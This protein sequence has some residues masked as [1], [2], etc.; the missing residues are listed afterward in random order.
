ML[1][2]ALPITSGDIVAGGGSIFII[3]VLNDNGPVL[4]RL[5]SATGARHRA[6]VCPLH[7]SELAYSGLP[8]QDIVVRCVPVWS[9]GTCHFTKL[10]HV[11]N[12]LRDR[13]TMALKREMLVRRF[14]DGP[15]MRSNLTAS[16]SS[17]GR[18]INAVRYA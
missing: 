17:S 16:T 9:C 4:L 11:S 5:E 2:G 18:R 3:H 12:T 7:W 13:I 10:G 15:S 8:L 14:E 6:D 1:F